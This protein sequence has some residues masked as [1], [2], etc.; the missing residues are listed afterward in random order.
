MKILIDTL[1][2]LEGRKSH[3]HILAS[4]DA[5]ITRNL[6]SLRLPLNSKKPIEI[7][8]RFYSYP[9]KFDNPRHSFKDGLIML[10][11]ETGYISRKS[12]HLTPS[13][14]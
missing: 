9:L 5:A 8:G 6:G 12:I 1:L 10:H 11:D 4:L 13:E 3:P 2:T 7:D 14:L